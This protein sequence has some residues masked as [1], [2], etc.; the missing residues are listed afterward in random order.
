MRTVT[1]RWPLGRGRYLIVSRL[2]GNS[3]AAIKLARTR[4][5]RDGTRTESEMLLGEEPV[6]RL[7]RLADE[8]VKVEGFE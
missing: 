4:R 2:A 3:Y 7:R 1:L 5:H 8:L 6:G